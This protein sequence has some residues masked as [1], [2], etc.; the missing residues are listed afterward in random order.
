MKSPSSVNS[1][2]KTWSIYWLGKLTITIYE[3]KWFFTRDVFFYCW[4]RSDSFLVF[5]VVYGLSQS[6]STEGA[7]FLSKLAEFVCFLQSKYPRNEM[8]FVL[9]S[10]LLTHSL[11]K[12]FFD[13]YCEYIFPDQQ[14]WIHKVPRQMIIIDDWAVC[15]LHTVSMPFQ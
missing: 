12:D 15:N 3:I 6:T 2:T 10:R 9:K 11:F 14:H 13:D 5:I 7:L 1:D 8:V 4:K